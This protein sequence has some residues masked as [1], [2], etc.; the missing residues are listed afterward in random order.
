MKFNAILKYSA[1]AVALSSSLAWGKVSPQE[2]ARLGDT[3][4]PVGAEK[5]GNADGTI[6]AWDGGLASPPAGFD[7]VNYIDPFAGESPKFEITAANADQYKDQLSVGQLAML[8]KY[9]D[10]KI[11]VFP[12]HRT[13]AYE[14]MIYDAAKKNATSAELVAD[15]NGMNDYELSVPFP[16]PSGSER[17][18]ALEI[19]WNHI[20]RWRDGSLKRNVVQMTPLANGEFTPVKFSEQLSY[21]TSLTDYNPSVDPNVIFYFKQEITSPA[22]LAGNVLLVHE[23]LDQVKEP[24]RAWIYNS[25]QRR[26]RRAPQVAYDGPGTASDGQRT[27]DNF[28]MFNGA[29]DRYNW[30]LLG[31]REVYIPYNSYHL[32]SKKVS[33]DEIIKPG[34]IN[35]DLARYELHR[36][37]VLEATLKP[38]ARHIYAK[39]V[40]YVDEDTWQIGLVDHYDGRGDLWRVAE[41]HHIYFYDQKI[42]WFTAEALYDLLSG[43][44]LVL[45]L[46]NEEPKG[47]EF[48]VESS[49]DEFTPAALRRAG[50]R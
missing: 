13:A 10:Y 21:R 30:K 42:S 32:N 14:Q 15:G 17:D 25:G 18:K 47:Y 34:H 1:I 43:R 27:T 20:T 2:A 24:R 46:T 6:P 29:P 36:V 44:Y 40:F 5:A 39:R 49:S 3:L 35:Q 38:G 41:G 19:M 50:R 7:G 45:G 31:K 33:Y 9:P 48:D 23:T 16:I 12:T 4:T 22:R 28:D 26:V 8:K 11:K 37:W